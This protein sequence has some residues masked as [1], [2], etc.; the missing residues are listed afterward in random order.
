MT[1]PS[2]SIT[3]PEGPALVFRLLIGGVIALV[4]GCSFLTS[5]VV[6]DLAP[7]GSTDVIT[8]WNQSTSAGDSFQALIARTA[9]AH[10]MTV[11]KE[12]RN[13]SGDAVV[14]RLFVANPDAVRSFRL[15]AHDTSGFDPTLTSRFSPISDL[16]SNRVSGMY[17][18]DAGT[19]AA[20]RF[21]K[22]LDDAGVTV[23][24]N[25]LGLA[26]VAQWTASEVPVVPLGAALLLVVVV[27]VVAWQASRRNI[28]AI[29]ASFGRSRRMSSM[30]DAGSL[31]ATMAVG[32]AAG[33]L[34][35]VPVLAVINGGARLGL[36]LTISGV[37]LACTTSF[38]AIVA[39]LTA[40]CARASLTHSI[41]GA[42]PWRSVLTV[43][44]V[45]NVLVVTLASSAATTAWQTVTL[46]END[47]AER[48]SWRS[49][50][51]DVRLTFT[52]SDADLDAAETELAAMFTR[53]DSAG[54]A[55]LADHV[56]APNRTS[57][58]PDEGNVLLV[59][60]QYVNEK[61]IRSSTGSRVTPE[62][63]DPKALTLLVPEGV[64]VSDPDMRAWREFLQ[65]QR[66]NAAKPESIPAEIE[67][68]TLPTT[69]HRVFTYATDDLW[70]TSTEQDTVI[71]VIP[72]ATPSMS[73]NLIV[74]NMT[75]GEVVFTDPEMLRADL[76][77]HD[78]TLA[79]IDPLRDAVSYRSAV[80]ERALRQQLAV[81]GVL[82]LVLGVSAAVTCQALTMIRRRRTMIA[83]THGRSAA[84][85]VGSSLTL[86]LLVLVLA[87]SG[88]V[89]TAA[90]EA[91]SAVI[92]C[93]AI[94]VLLV[95]AAT[96]IHGVRLAGPDARRP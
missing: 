84:R 61:T 40:A 82:V 49:S 81:L 28:A 25:P 37:G 94:D 2:A 54:T 91:L 59:N 35:M 46:A 51:E 18:T 80:I 93:V 36:F 55:V 20:V 43:S 95:I 56:V 67:I 52:T 60:A 48:G 57:H 23:T 5:R 3:H 16:P 12:V 69:T 14:R 86:P 41:S 85:A 15:S 22:S 50:L 53:L 88:L 77:A 34:L 74:S 44:L 26:S 31:V 66:S 10:D 70:T 62:T 19:A 38:A 78:L 11:L 30:R 9:E 76:A 39:L 24:V 72:S 89:A 17:L 42:R 58:G 63:L 75:S 4:L 79:T 92:G 96:A 27:G 21:A 83:R 71:A 29:N 6:D 64:R 32:G 13:E 87:G 47:A 90:E 33:M 7:A 73:E 8:V 65:F 1:G 68:T 45:S